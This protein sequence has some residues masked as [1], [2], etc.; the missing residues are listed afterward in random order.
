MPRLSVPHAFNMK[1][2]FKMKTSR[3]SPLGNFIGKNIFLYFREKYDTRKIG[4]LNWQINLICTVVPELWGNKKKKKKTWSHFTAAVL[5]GMI[6]V[7]N[8]SCLTMCVWKEMKCLDWTKIL[9]SFNWSSNEMIWKHLFVFF[10]LI[11]SL[12]YSV[13]LTTMLSST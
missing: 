10:F 5:C 11:I 7:C 4:S 6:R 12:R 1:L 2:Q 13:L 8:V 9:C 3:W